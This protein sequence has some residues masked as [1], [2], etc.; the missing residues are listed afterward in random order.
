MSFADRAAGYLERVEQALDARLPAE[1]TRPA[2]LHAAMRYSVLGGGKRVR[3]LLCYAAGETLGVA[4]DRLDDAACAVEC[5]HAFSLVHDDLPAMDDDALRRGKPSTHKAFGVATAILAG[6][7][8]H[9]RAF[10]ILAGDGVHA[11]AERLG[12]IAIL[13]SATGSLGMTGGQAVDLESEGR[14]LA[15][16]DLE[17]LDR[18]KTGRLIRAAVLMPCCAVPGLP[19]ATRDAL[20]RFAANMGLAF[21]IKDDVLDVEGD[22][23]LTGKTQGADAV[24]GKATYPSLMGLDHARQRADALYA[25]ALAALE[26]FGGAAEPLRWLARYIVHRDR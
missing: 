1:G 26:P 18:D 14:Q 23:A 22:Q 25:D 3:P 15:V 8:L 5:V 19:G 17:A 24:R 12:M 9:T 7:A 21:Q 16:D 13:A 10:E 2:T 11:A 4:A 20:D 6:D